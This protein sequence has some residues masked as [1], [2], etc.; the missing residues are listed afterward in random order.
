MSWHR[1]DPR[2]PSEGGPIWN[3]FYK[4]MA[5]PATVDNAIEGDTQEARDA[6]HR[7]LEARKK[8]SREQRE[9]KRAAHGV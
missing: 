1:K 9:R 8:W 4:F 7:D 6:W 5:G 2:D 3:A